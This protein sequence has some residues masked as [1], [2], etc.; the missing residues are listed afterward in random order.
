MK[1]KKKIV[2]RLM[3]VI[4]TMQMLL[5][6]S[7]QTAFAAGNWMPKLLGVTYSEDLGCFIAVGSFSDTNGAIMTSTDGLTWTLRNGPA[8]GAR[9]G[10]PSS[11][12]Y[13]NPMNSSVVWGNNQAVVLDTCKASSYATGRVLVTNSDLS[14][15][16]F[17]N[18]RDTAGNT[19]VLGS[20]CYDKAS[21]KY[22]ATPYTATN[23]IYYTS[24]PSQTNAWTAL[25]V[26]VSSSNLSRIVSDNN[27]RICATRDY[28]R[29][30]VITAPNS[31]ATPSVLSINLAQ[32]ITISGLIYDG[33]PNGAGHFIAANQKD[34]SIWYLD[35]TTVPATPTWKKVNADSTLPTGWTS[36]NSYQGLA[37]NGTTIIAM[38]NGAN[39]S[40]VPTDRKLS[41]LNVEIG[42]AHV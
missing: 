29:V 3:V 24:D 1:N 41:Y 17:Y 27:G 12:Q 5:V 9:L 38:P 18:T 26:N 36:A 25:T 35:T 16:A 7:V 6:L 28:G 32:P 19:I 11:E 21:Q 8:I 4:L 15:W 22:F 42:R 33:T 14:S 39:S 31:T 37:S 13:N 30:A 2:S 40:A 34:A 10:N 23:T 20:I